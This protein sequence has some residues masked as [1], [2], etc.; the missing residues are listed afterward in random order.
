MKDISL[1][2]TS[3]GVMKDISL[4]SN[5][6]KCYLDEYMYTNFIWYKG[7]IPSSLLLSVYN[8]LPSSSSCFLF[9]TET[10]FLILNVVSLCAS[11]HSEIILLLFETQDEFY[12][13]M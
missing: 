7:D 4:V 13:Y 11:H 9:K 6:P 1:V 3:S 10:A 8:H 2:Q 12:I 5:D